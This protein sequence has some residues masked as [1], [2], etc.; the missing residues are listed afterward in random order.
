[1]TERKFIGAFELGGI[2]GKTP[3]EWTDEELDSLADKIFEAIIAR[4]EENE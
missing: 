4:L 3:S 2:E 1:M